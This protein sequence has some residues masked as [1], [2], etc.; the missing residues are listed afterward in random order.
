MRTRAHWALP[1]VLVTA[2]AVALSAA[3]V[4]A[5]PAEPAPVV[6][7]PVVSASSPPLEQ[8]VRA[9]RATQA[10]R[11]ARVIAP[12]PVLRRQMVTVPFVRRHLQ[13]F[14]EIADA[15]GGNRAAGT[16]GYD[17]SAAYVAGRLRRA[18]YAVTLQEFEFPF[19]REITETTVSRV[20]PQPKVYT[21]ETDFTTMVYSGSGRVTAAV[22]PVDLTLP[23]GAVNTSTSGCEAG[24][25][26]GFP[27]GDIALVQRGT[28]TFQVKAENAQAA[29][30]GGVIIFNEGQEGEGDADRRRLLRGNLGAPNT[31]I[32]VVGTTFAIGQELSAPGTTVS[33]VA[34]TQSDPKR[35]TRNVLAESRRGD[36]SKVVMVGAHLDSVDEGPGINDNGSGSAAVLETALKAAMLPTVNRLRFAFWGAEE[37]GLLG[38]QHYVTSL[39]PEEKAK[40]KMYLNFDMIASPNYVFSIYDGDDSD[41]VGSPA[42]PPGSDEIEKFFESYYTAAGLPYTGDDFTGRSDYGPFIAAGIPSGGVFTGAEEIKTAEEAQR[43]GG[44]AGTAYDPC[45]HQAC[46][47]IDNIDARALT[48]NTGAIAAATF[49]YAYAADLPG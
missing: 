24:D 3:P 22:R 1:A 34:N 45:Y 15:N 49:A 4:S 20:S 41:A 9:A 7:A 42:G 21:R 37:L 44:T 33:L 43:F 29:G 38:S 5:L 32:P 40:I 28:C 19:F 26:A 47:T 35:R 2:S 30:A 16:S 8:A 11:I 14:Q 31:R 25:F 39:P 46:D 18:G 17:A 23:P 12:D 6:S 27:P 36:P 48:V 13:T 10:T